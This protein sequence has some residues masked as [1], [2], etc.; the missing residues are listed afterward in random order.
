MQNSEGAVESSALP[1]P[2]S[3]PL[4]P[5]PW[6]VIAE[7]VSKPASQP[8]SDT[9]VPLNGGRIRKESLQNHLQLL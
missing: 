5:S 2:E 6:N 8:I 9:G 3:L 4:Q 7:I 1:N